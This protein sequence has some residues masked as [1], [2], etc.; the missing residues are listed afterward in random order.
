LEKISAQHDKF[1]PKRPAGYV[2]ILAVPYSSPPARQSLP[3]DYVRKLKEKKHIIK[4]IMK[5]TK[6]TKS[7]ADRF[8]ELKRAKDSR[9]AQRERERKEEQRK[10]TLALQKTTDPPPISPPLYFDFEAVQPRCKLRPSSGKSRPPPSQG[11]KRGRGAAGGGKTPVQAK[12]RT[13]ELKA[14]DYVHIME[15]GVLRNEDGPKVIYLTD[16]EVLMPCCI[17]GP[18]CGFNFLNSPSS[19][20]ELFVPECGA[21]TFGFYNIPPETSPLAAGACTCVSCLFPSSSSVCCN[22]RR[23]R[24]VVVVG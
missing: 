11:D 2:P 22:A 10:T 1:A 8:A 13:L 18:H 6:D 4:Q 3:N 24:R 20:V 14:G 21:D 12:M 17:D 23:G 15:D 5:E 7:E 16:T 9:R 19:A